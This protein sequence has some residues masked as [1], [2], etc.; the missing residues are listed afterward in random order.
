MTHRRHILLITVGLLVATGCGKVIS[1][2]IRFESADDEPFTQGECTLFVDMVGDVAEKNMLERQSTVIK[3]APQG[4][5]TFLWGGYGKDGLTISVE[6]SPET[7]RAVVRDTSMDPFGKIRRRSHARVTKEL[8][9]ELYERFADRSQS[10]QLGRG[11]MSNRDV[12][13]TVTPLACAAV[14]PAG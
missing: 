10:M 13:P 1:N 4:H 11:G 7:L 3:K 2:T 14:A 5:E 6:C 12:N 9:Q 8:A